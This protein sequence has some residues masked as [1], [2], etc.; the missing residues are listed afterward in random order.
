MAVRTEVNIAGVV[1]KNPVVTGSGTFGFGR[2]YAEFID[3]NEIGAVNVK[4]L[5]LKPRL[6]NPVPRV[7][8]TPAGML[9][10]VGLQNPGVEVFIQKE[11]PWLKQFDCKVIANVNGGSI[12]D[13]V[14]MAEILGETETDLLEINLSCPNVK[15]GC[16][17]FGT[18]PKMVY[19]VTKAV[20]KVAKQPIIIKLTPN[21]TSIV[22]IAKAAVDGGADSLSLINTLLGMAIDIHKRQPILA[23]VMGGLSG[24]C[25]KPVAVRMVYQVAQ[26]VDVPIMGMGG[27]MNADDAVEFMLA[28]ADVVS[29]G[30]ANF[31]NPTATVEV[32][33]GIVDYCEKYGYSDVNQL[34]GNLRG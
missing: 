27:I 3:L 32:A 14:Q 6:G 30:T 29:V 21:V 22:E 17:V 4:G 23:N 18:D 34:V 5:T 25:V 12:E 26:A 8:E 7:A 9:N 11:L 15:E 16:M 19:E 28:G 33:K 10:S 1:L 20:K 31:M 2:E 24:P 13:Y